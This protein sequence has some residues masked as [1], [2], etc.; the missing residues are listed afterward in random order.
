MSLPLKAK[1]FPSTD[2]WP[3]LWGAGSFR[4]HLIL[5][6]IQGSLQKYVQSD[7]QKP[8]AQKHTYQKKGLRPGRA[9]WLT[10]V[11]PALWEA[12][13]SRS[14]E[15][16]ISR[17]AWPTWWSPISTKNTKITRAWGWA[18][19]VRAT[20]EAEAWELLEPG[21]QRLQWAPLHFSLGYRARLH[22]KK[23]RREKK[24]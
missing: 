8:Q 10:P 18:P 19:V 16:R 15:V 24:R 21:R 7:M 5:Q 1:C 23:K 11:T 12:K 22:F 3:L 20:W 14:L 4:P 6:K 2:V 17:P 13:A 9:H